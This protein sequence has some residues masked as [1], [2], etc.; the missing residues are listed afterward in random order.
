[1]THHEHPNSNVF[2]LIAVLL[3]FLLI[4]LYVAAAVRSSRQ[5]KPFP[6][7]RYVC[8]SVGICSAAVA[9]IGPLAEQAHHNFISH[10]LVHLLLGMLAP[11][12]LTLAAPMTL[13]LR[14]M[15]TK[16]S[17]TL[18]KLMRSAPIRFLNDPIPA[19]ILTLG[20]LW[21]LYA[22]DLYLIMQQ[23][24]IVHWIV[25]FHLLAAGYLFTSAMLQIDLAVH[26][27]SFV[28][29]TVVLL[30]ALAGHGILSKYLYANPPAGVPS[31]QVEIGSMLMYYGGD[32]VD[33]ILI[34]ILFSQW[35]KA[36][37]PRVS[38]AP[39]TSYSKG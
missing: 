17:R 14:T 6:L 24:G 10:M 19:S 2:E 9:V 33:A 7:Y 21:M 1:M 37:R 12:L 32:A 38:I 26:R 16:W 23:N 30:F 8:W 27:T 11:L 20:G 15:P 25:H 28:Y 36:T 3:F 13:L 34:T 4:V 29:R 39:S 31:A 22:T 35:Y 5:F 18:S